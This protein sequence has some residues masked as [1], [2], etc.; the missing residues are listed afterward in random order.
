MLTDLTAGALADAARR[1]ES[2]PLEVVEA[3]ALARKPALD[4]LA[5]LAPAERVKI[6]AEVKR[7]SPSRGALAD[8]PD[9]AE[10]AALYER[11]GA[12]AI[13]V[14][15]E[16]RRFK[17]SLADLEAVRERVS[18]PVLR[19]DFIAEPYQVFEARAAGADLVLLI[20]AALEQPLLTELHALVLELGMTPLVETHSADELERA[21]DLGARL[22]GVNARNLTTFELD[23]DLFGR[24]SERIP[25][26]AVKVAESA[27]KTADDVAHYRRSGADVVLVGEALVTGGDPVSTLASFLA[28]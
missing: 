12:S 8:I 15:T 10:L 23:R 24:L 13:S 5:A 9:P 7:A 25:A 6:I 27:V 4:A 3:R 21:V 18:I 20:V 19:K 1:R 26:G 17:G 16:E 14:L 28:I 22:I 2:A 11:G